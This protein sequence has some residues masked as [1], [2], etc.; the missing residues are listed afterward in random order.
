MRALRSCRK[1]QARAFLRIYAQRLC[2][3]RAPGLCAVRTV[4]RRHNAFSKTLHNYAVR[5]DMLRDLRLA[6]GTTKRSLLYAATPRNSPL[7]RNIG[8]APS[9]LSFAPRIRVVSMQTQMPNITKRDPLAYASFN[10]VDLARG[11]Q[12][13]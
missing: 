7:S 8:T 5:V 10:V 6:G 12:I 11:A 13:R 2:S 3:T 1:M 4:Y 9:Q